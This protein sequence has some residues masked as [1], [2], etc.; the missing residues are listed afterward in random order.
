VYRG[1]QWPIRVL[2]GAVS[3]TAILVAVA[4]GTNPLLVVAI[5]LVVGGAFVWAI[6]RGGVYA[7]AAGIDYRPTVSGRPAHWDWQDVERFE[8]FQAKA[9]GIVCIVLRDGIREPLRPTQGWRYQR[10]EIKTICDKLNAE[11]SRAR[12]GADDPSWGR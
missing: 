12:A 4:D 1:D 6:E 11:L 3:L 5:V 10:D 8:V 2:L 7:S 9:Q